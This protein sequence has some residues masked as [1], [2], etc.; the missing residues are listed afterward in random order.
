MG[1]FSPINQF[2]FA[3]LFTVLFA[4]TISAQTQAEPDL[5]NFAQGVLPLE[6][7]VGAEELRIKPEHAIAAI[8]GNH[9]RFVAMGKP[10]NAGQFV[11]FVYALPAGTTFSAFSVPNVKETPSPSQTF[12]K[13]IEVLGS[14]QGTNGPFVLLA[15]GEV[16]SSAE[17][18]DITQ[19]QMEPQQPKVEWVK[20]RM[21][22]GV[23][24][25]RDQTFLEFS[26]LIGHGVQ[27]EPELS[28]GFSGVWR[29]R[30]VKLE[31]EQEGATVTGCYD[32][33]AMLSGTMHG[34]VLRALG[35]NDAG[36][37]SQFILIASEDGSI[38]GLRSTNGAPFKSYDGDVSDAAAACFES[39]QPKLGCGSV[40]HG[41][42]FDFDSDVIRPSSRVVLAD[43]YNGLSEAG[44]SSVRI[45]GHSSSEGADDYNRDLSQRRAASV[46]SA[47]VA[48]GMEASVLSA[49]GRG[50]D[51][52]IASN[53]DE[54]GRSLNRR[55]E[56]RCSS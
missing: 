5:M 43:L 7:S 12:F 35:Q 33:N 41:I 37:S 42:Q 17:E 56:V 47:L 22:D 9:K 36:I 13:T 28:T 38:R 55:V 3:A 8:D 49:V 24:V 16:A 21:T 50:E 11:E 39:E 52:P 32:G 15:R 26:E 31:L 6:I 20:L 2:T 53:E 23:D 4:D 40:L 48:L 10:A 1:Q 34:N 29:G 44:A 25:Q 54:A 46:V 19:L 45:V 14:P 51:D 30:G 27:D 18:G